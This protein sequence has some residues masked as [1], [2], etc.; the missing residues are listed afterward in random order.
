MLAFF[1]VND[2]QNNET[3]TQYGLQKP[4]FLNTDLE[5]ANVPVPTP[6]QEAPVIRTKAGRLELTMAILTAMGKECK[7]VGAQFVL[8]K[9]GRFLYPDH[10]KMISFDRNFGTKLGDVVNGPYFDLDAA[11][12]SEG[13]SAFVLLNGNNDGHW[14]AFGHEQTAILLERFLKEQGL[15]R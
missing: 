11:F 14:N 15:L 6:F 4:V 3:S 1:L 8:M 13:F 12:K 5:L 10:P 2:V 9:F 7:N